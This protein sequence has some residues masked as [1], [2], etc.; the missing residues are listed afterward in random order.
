MTTTSS[1]ALRSE[2]ATSGEK[3]V[4][5]CLLITLAWMVYPLI[6]SARMTKSE[7]FA[8][9]SVLVYS[10]ALLFYVNKL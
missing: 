7:R 8:F 10:A 4:L 2:G 1:S 6:A 5:F 9:Y 3:A